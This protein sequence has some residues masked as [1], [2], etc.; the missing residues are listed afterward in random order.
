MKSLKI[1][2][3][4]LLLTI[5]NV[6]YGQQRGAFD[7]DIRTIQNYDKIYKAPDHA[8]LFVGSSSI[9]KWDDME[10]VLG[11]YKVLNRGIGGAYINGRSSYMWVRMT[12]Q[13]KRKRR[14]LF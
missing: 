3:L 10:E 1:K 4:L 2:I 7:A 13:K 6:V 9:R 12:L 8:I 11:S 5:C 14:T